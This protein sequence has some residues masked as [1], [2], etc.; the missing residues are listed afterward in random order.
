M[1]FL[2][3]AL[4]TVVGFAAASPMDGAQDLEARSVGS[5]IAS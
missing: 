1:K 3:V 4:A 2:I 5:D